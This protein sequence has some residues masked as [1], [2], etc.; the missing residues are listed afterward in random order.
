[1]ARWKC[2][3]KPANIEYDDGTIERPF[4]RTDDPATDEAGILRW[5]TFKMGSLQ[6]AK[7]AVETLLTQ[8]PD[9]MKLAA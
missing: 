4:K 5:L 3:T 8:A 6:Q 1:M 9:N 7:I 2:G